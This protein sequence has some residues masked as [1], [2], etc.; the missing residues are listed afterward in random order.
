VE[1]LVRKYA[2]KIGL[3]SAVPVHSLRVTA[4]TTARERGADILDL[5]D[6]AGHADPRTTLSYI[7]SRDRL[8]KSPAHVL[9]Y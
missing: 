1:N 4:L 5:Q 7:R 3:D 6:F 9:K 8:S 2:S